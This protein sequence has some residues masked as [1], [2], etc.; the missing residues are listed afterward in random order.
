MIQTHCSRSVT[1]LG[2]LKIGKAERLRK[3]SI[4]L[5]RQ[6]IKENDGGRAAAVLLLVELT[7][8]EPVTP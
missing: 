8:V 7:G 1:A 5:S 6:A 3:S 4:I 2:A